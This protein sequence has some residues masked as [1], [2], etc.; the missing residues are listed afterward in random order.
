MSFL[1]EE[2]VASEE[3]K[4]SDDNDSNV[5]DVL[6]EPMESKSGRK[7]KPSRR[8]YENFDDRKKSKSK[9][10]KK[11]DWKSKSKRTTISATE[12]VEYEIIVDKTPALE[13][14]AGTA[15]VCGY[16]HKGHQDDPLE[17]GKRF[18][19][20]GVTTHY[21]CMLFTYN[22]NQLGADSEGLFGFYGEEV[23]QQIEIG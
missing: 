6:N 22:S 11:S 3:V 12:P 7:I 9:G 10:N 19:I 8:I 17:S 16:C 15:A 5:L 21:F 2:Q 4:S 23:K 14:P 20:S 1:H 18:S 13:I